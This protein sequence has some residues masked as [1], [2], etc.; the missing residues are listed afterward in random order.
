MKK[1]F[2]AATAALAFS[3][4]PVMAETATGEITDITDGLVTLSTKDGQ[5]M[6]FQTTDNTT[7][8]Q[9]KM[10]RKN[11]HKKGMRDGENWRYIPI[12]EEEDWVEIVYDPKTGNGT[13]YEV[14]TITVFDK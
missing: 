9:K 3:V 1:M 14:D 2:Y 5:E 6:M 10:H 11:K 7:Y 12:A 13:I 8:R 4:L